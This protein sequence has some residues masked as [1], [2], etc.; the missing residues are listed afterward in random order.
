ME[1]ILIAVL[2]VALAVA[3][4]TDIKKREVPDWLSYGLV[5]FGLGANLLLSIVNW[6]IFPLLYSVLGFGIFFAFAFLMYYTGQW[7]GGD[8]KLLMGVGAVFGFEFSKS[9]AVFFFSPLFSFFMNLLLVGVVYAM[10]LA[11][12]AAFRRRKKFSREFVKV[13]AAQRY[14]RIILGMGAVLVVVALV[15]GSPLAKL[16][17]GAVAVMLASLPYIFAFSK[18]IE[19]ACMLSRVNPSKLT[20]GDWIAQNVVVGK[21][22]I[23]GPKDLGVSKRQIALLNRLYRARKVRNVVVKNG[24]PFVPSFLAALAVT[25][26][27]GN[28]MFFLLGI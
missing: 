21:K 15:S 8:S 2:F 5:A 22:I 27:Y 12:I 3:S 26:F 28:L 10:V 14:R 25:V 24:I 23:A 18:S 1:S 6:S 19:N 11:V 4:Y 9:I 16:L 17:F 13:L 7:G 20:E